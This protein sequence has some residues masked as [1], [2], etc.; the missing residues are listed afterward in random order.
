MSIGA[1][2]IALTALTTLME[3]VNIG[4]GERRLPLSSLERARNAAMAIADN[5]HV[6]GKQAA[7][8]PREALNALDS[9]RDI[10]PTN[11]CWDAVADMLNELY[12]TLESFQTYVPVADAT[13]LAGWLRRAQNQLKPYSQ[14]F[15]RRDAQ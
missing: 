6:I 13:D 10:D 1:W 8:T 3:A 2:W 4:W 5:M 15:V 11:P 7:A 9:S 14:S 12:A